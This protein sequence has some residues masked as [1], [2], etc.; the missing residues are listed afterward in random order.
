MAQNNPKIESPLHDPPAALTTTITEK[1]PT[2]NSK[3]HAGNP[4]EEE[5]PKREPRPPCPSTQQ[6]DRSPK[7]RRPAEK[8]QAFSTP[9]SPAAQRK[10]L[11]PPQTRLPRKKNS[12]RPEPKKAYSRCKG[13]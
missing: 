11:R 7:K 4:Q 13:A 8:E 1:E 10:K 5:Q 6:I 9:E 3:E 2:R 12:A